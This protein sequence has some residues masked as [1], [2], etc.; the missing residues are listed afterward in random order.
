[1]DVFYN[2]MKNPRIDFVEDPYFSVS[3]LTPFVAN[4]LK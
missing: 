2:S 3:L 1:M 4:F